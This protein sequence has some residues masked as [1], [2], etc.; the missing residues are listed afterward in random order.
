MPL[1][2]RMAIIE[3]L[4][5]VDQVIVT[6]PDII[7]RI[8]AWKKLRYDAFFTG[9][10]WLGTPGQAEA[11]KRLNELGADLVFFPYTKEQSTTR[12]RELLYGG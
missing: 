3:A 7:P 2:H 1:E 10:D 12:L 5:Y 6:T 8:E 11:E 9:D 4:R